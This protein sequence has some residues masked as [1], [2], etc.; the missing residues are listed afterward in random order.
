LLLCVCT[1]GPARPKPRARIPVGDKGSA[2][3]EGCANVSIS[4]L[5]NDIMLKSVNVRFRLTRLEDGADLISLR[6]SICS[7]GM[8]L[9]N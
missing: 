9:R 2:A 4:L 5:C 6:K 1:V 7:S 8:G 3:A